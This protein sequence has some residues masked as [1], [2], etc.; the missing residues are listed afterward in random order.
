MKKGFTL[1][2]V[3]A[4][5]I[6]LGVISVIVVP[7]VME[8]FDKNSIKIY[9]INENLLKNAAK[10]YVISHD[11]FLITDDYKYINMDTLVE[12][13]LMTSIV[14]PKTANTCKAFVKIS[15]NEIDGYNYDVCLI[16]DGYTT[17]EDFCTSSQYEDI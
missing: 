16:C 4:V 7:N 10:D 6:I 9:K 3:L 14:D 17:N 11:D 5:I 15:N 8:T 2:E 13:N 12:E 1:V